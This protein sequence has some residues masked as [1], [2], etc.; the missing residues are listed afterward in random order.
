MTTARRSIGAQ[1]NPESE[2]AILEAA[3]E[4]LVEEGLGGFSIEAVAR[5]ARAGKPTIYRWWPNRTLLLLAVYA[6]LKEEVPQADTGT[7][8]GDVRAFIANLLAFWRETPAGPVFKSV[9]AAAQ[10]D[11]EASAV[12]AAYHRERHAETA[13]RFARHGLD[14]N[15]AGLLTELAVDYCWAR[16]L[17]DELDASNEEIA[18]VAAALTRG[19]T[20]SAS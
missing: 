9:I 6:G 5:R 3:R 12:L 17:V 11:P 2:T 1:R 16:L 15:A 13:Q 8:E 18:R 14:M 4:L 7:L 19:V 10:A 20:A